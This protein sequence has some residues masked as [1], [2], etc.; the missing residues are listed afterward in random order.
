M[1]RKLRLKKKKISLKA[2][3]CSTGSFLFD[4]LQEFGDYCFSRLMVFPLTDVTVE[5]KW[6]L[7]VHARQLFLEDFADVVASAFQ[8]WREKTVG[9]AEHLR[10][11]IKILYLRC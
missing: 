3:A 6:H 9:D 1:E 8:G 7:A 2:T 5:S 10:M 11:Q 4:E